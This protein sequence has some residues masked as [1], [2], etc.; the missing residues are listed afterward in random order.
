MVV[1]SDS[2]RLPGFCVAFRRVFCV[3]RERKLNFQAKAICRCPFI[4]YK[5]KIVV[6]ALAVGH[7]MAHIPF[8]LS[9]A[10]AQVADQINIERLRMQYLGRFVWC[11]GSF[12][13]GQVKGIAQIALD[14][15]G[16][17]SEICLYKLLNNKPINNAGR[18][19]TILCI[20][21]IS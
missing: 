6:V 2:S 12:Y 4:L 3:K 7:T 5:G 19:L 10:G 17:G 9:F 13:I 1:L 18:N 20:L 8:S 15:K 14:T 16:V 11:V 21:R